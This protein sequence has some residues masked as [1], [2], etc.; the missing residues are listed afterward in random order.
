MPES[1]IARDEKIQSRQNKIS[2]ALS[3]LVKVVALV[4]INKSMLPRPQNS[5]RKDNT[6]VAGGKTTHYP[7][8]Q[9]TQNRSS[10]YPRRDQQTYNWKSNK[11]S[12]VR[13]LR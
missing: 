5:D 4:S 2:A 3:A 12:T 13:Q 10:Y 1:T 8:F 9:K 6:S 11:K 7:K